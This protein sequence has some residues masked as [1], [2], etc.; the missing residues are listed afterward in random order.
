MKDLKRLHVS[1]TGN[2]NDD[3]KNVKGQ[4]NGELG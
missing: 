1:S 2:D 3:G 4:Y